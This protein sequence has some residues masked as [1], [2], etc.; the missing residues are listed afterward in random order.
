[1]KT[2][3]TTLKWMQRIWVFLLLPILGMALYFDLSRRGE[4][5]GLAL[6]LVYPVFKIFAWPLGSLMMFLLK[7]KPPSM[8][9]SFE[10]S[11][12]ILTAQPF[13]GFLQWFVL[14]PWIFRGWSFESKRRF[15]IA[16]F[17]SIPIALITWLV[18]WLF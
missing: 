8:G 13:V 12:I 9:E 5:G 17:A 15:W 10:V 2:N 18:L 1:M 4:G 7:H 11:V 6:W 16:W 14:V 3:D